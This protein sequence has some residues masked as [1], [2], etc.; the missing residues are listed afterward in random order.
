M[1]CKERLKA[2]RHDKLLIS[3]VIL[4]Y[5]FLALHIIGYFDSNGKFEV[6]VRAC[7]VAL[8]PLFVFIGGRKGLRFWGVIYAYILFWYS[9]TLFYTPFIMIALLSTKFS[10]FRTIIVFLLYAILVSVRSTINDIAPFRV[11]F[12]ALK[13]C[14][15]YFGIKF[16]V[17]NTEPQYLELSPDEILILDELA[18]GKNLNELTIFSSNTI[19]KKLKNARERNGIKTNEELVMKYVNSK[20]A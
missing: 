18:K 15:F 8:Y 9:G 14:V 7:A 6:I 5:V 10:L 17:E 1:N 4:S 20:K 19:C 16:L 13:C 2:L 11:I 12:H 3:T